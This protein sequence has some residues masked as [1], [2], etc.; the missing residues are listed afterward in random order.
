MIVVVIS[1]NVY[2]VFYLS[3]KK[4][5]LDYII[6]KFQFKL[7]SNTAKQLIAILLIRKYLIFISNKRHGVFLLI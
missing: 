5:E 7:S 1:F 4:V 2:N 6:E 3:E